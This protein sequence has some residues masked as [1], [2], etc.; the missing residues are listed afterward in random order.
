[1]YKSILRV[2]VSA[3]YCVFGIF[4]IVFAYYTGFLG[5]GVFFIIP[6]AIGVA[7]AM[8][9]VLFFIKK[10]A[11]SIFLSTGLFLA[12]VSWVVYG[13]MAAIAS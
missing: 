5:G 3:I 13:V 7:W 10:I 4:V 6:I 1:M 12:I 8:I 2:I 9:G 11:L